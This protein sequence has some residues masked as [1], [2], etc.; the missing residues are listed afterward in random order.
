M[1]HA[2]SGTC[3]VEWIPTVIVVESASRRM[4]VAF[5]DAFLLHPANRAYLIG[6][7]RLPVGM[8][9][10]D[11]WIIGAVALLGAVFTLLFLVKGCWEERKIAR[12]QSRGVRTVA[13]VV[14][15]SSSTGPGVSHDPDIYDVTYTYTVDGLEY[16]ECAGLSWAEY[17][18]LSQGSRIQ[19]RYDPD[20]PSASKLER[21][22]IERER[23]GRGMVPVFA[24]LIFMALVFIGWLVG[25]Y[26]RAFRPMLRR[27]RTAHILSG[28]VVEC[29]GKMDE[30]I[31]CV[32]LAYRFTDPAG[33]EIANRAEAIR[34]DLQRS[35]LPTPGMPVTFRISSLSAPSF[36]AIRETMVAF[37]ASGSLSIT[38]LKP[39]SLPAASFSFGRAASAVAAL[40]ARSVRFCNSTMISVA[41]NWRRRSG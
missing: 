38:N 33:Q 2:S 7:R 34:V 12:L 14:D 5:D 26:I 28:A 24:L 40:T 13:T 1:R 21:V 17:T 9:R 20:D 29:T 11:V 23:D 36:D 37:P 25:W 35:P 8:A 27:R 3:L 4:T 19:I 15:L 22:F 16:R 6:K 10:P 31:F 18:D 32:E 41:C 39:S 30:G